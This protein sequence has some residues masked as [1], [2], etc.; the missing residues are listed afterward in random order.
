MFLRD[1]W[2]VAAWDDEVGHRPL[3]RT[4]LNE[5]VVLYRGANGRPV[6]LEDRCCH[7]HLPLR[8]GKVD[9]DNIQC[10]YHGPTF[11]RQGQCVSIPGQTAVPLGASVKSYPVVERDRWIWIWM[12]D[13]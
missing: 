4:L 2:Y 9:G 10:G 8:M 11:D 13:P 6:A 12:G 7:R 3:A 1:V 5:A